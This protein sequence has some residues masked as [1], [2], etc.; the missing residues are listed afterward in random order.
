MDIYPIPN[1][2]FTIYFNMYLPQDKLK[3]DGDTMKVP[4]E[5]VIQL[6]Y[7]RAL[8]ERGEDGGLTSSE[9]FALFKNILTD[10]ISIEVSRYPEEEV[11]SAT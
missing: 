11:W 4:A 2:L 9:A 6:A 1:D 3:G 10:Y 8:V 5:P 7:A